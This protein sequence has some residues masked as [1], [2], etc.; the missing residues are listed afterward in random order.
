VSHFTHGPKWPQS[1][2]EPKTAPTTAVEALE[3]LVVQ[4]TLCLAAPTLSR[5]IAIVD[6]RTMSVRARLAQ[7]LV[8]QATWVAQ[9]DASTADLLT[10]VPTS[11]GV[12]TDGWH[13]ACLAE[14]RRHVRQT[15]GD[16]PAEAAANALEHLV[17]LHGEAMRAELSMQVQGA[18]QL[19]RSLFEQHFWH[20]ASWVDVELKGRLVYR[21]RFLE[22][23]RS[24]VPRWLRL[25]LA[26]IVQCS[27]AAPCRFEARAAAAAAGSAGKT[28]SVCWRTSS[29][30]QSEAIRGNQMQS[31]AITSVGV[32]AYVEQL[33]FGWQA[34][35]VQECA[36]GPGRTRALEV[37]RVPVGRG[38]GGAVVSTCMRACARGPR[39]LAPW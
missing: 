19:L 17:E 12:W 10:G 28:R 25:L 16:V 22:K 8:E 23:V 13:A 5:L 33:P 24:D 32:L 6:E 21:E 27:A 38:D 34:R 3:R 20:I 1:N 31:E 26:S 18:S 15:A 11:L 29:S 37:Q 9:Q 30:W 39:R 4:P 7:S 36:E 35:A 14:V 2:A